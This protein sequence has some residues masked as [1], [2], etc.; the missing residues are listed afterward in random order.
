MGAWDEPMEEYE[1]DSPS[2]YVLRWIVEDVRALA[3]AFTSHERTS[4]HDRADTRNR[5]GSAK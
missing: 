1:T 2:K 3:P 4:V 5:Y